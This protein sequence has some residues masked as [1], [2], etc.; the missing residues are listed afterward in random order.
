V[1]DQVILPIHYELDAN[2]N[3]VSMSDDRGTESYAYD[4][5]NRLTQVTYADGEVVTY[6]YDARATADDGEQRSRP[7]DV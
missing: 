5:L 4:N 3:R 2:G 7:D 6:S 1:A